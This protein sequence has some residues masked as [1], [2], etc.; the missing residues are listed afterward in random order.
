MVSIGRI[1]NNVGKLLFDAKYQTVV[2]QSIKN[3]G[4]VFK[5]AGKSRFTNFGTQIKDGFK[6]AE[7]ATKGTNVWKGMKDSAM[8]L[9]KDV[10]NAWKAGKGF[11]SSFKGA[12]NELVKRLPLIG[13]ALM[14]A[15]ELPNI[16]KAT[17]DE[18]IGSGL[19]ETG[20]ATARLAS[21]AA[22]AAIGQAICPI[23]I[24]G[25]LLG[26]IAGEMLASAVVGKTYT[27]KKMEAEEAAKM[28]YNQSQSSNAP[29]F[30][31]YSANSQVPTMTPQQ[32]QQLQNAYM[33]SAMGTMNDDFMMNATGM[34]SMGYN[35][36]N[37]SSMNYMMNQPQN[38]NYM[39]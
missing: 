18:G 36:M 23:P 27:E 30:G 21:G 3:S 1:A 26:W 25:G 24:V 2:E 16:F 12:G 19:L 11:W 6:A 7:N 22:C 35:M 29:A 8:S 39:G 20:K 14:I 10:K 38:L 31:S 15:F 9:P 5:A 33:M 13:S 34:N 32:I 17:T 4:S 28:A 37:P